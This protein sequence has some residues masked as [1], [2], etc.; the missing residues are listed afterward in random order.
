MINERG[1]ATLE[2]R[3]GFRFETALLYACRLHAKQTR[4]GGQT[5]YLGHL[6][7][8]ASQVIEMG[9]D[10]DQAI[11]AL[12]HDAIEDQGGELTGEAIR[13]LYGGRVVDIIR[14][15][16]DDDPEFAERT[17][18][19]SRARKERYLQHLS[20][21]PRDVLMVSLADKL[22]NARSILLDLH[23]LGDDLWGRFNAGK[24]DQLW[25]YRGLVSAFR[26]ALQGDALVL[27]VDELDRVVREIERLAKEA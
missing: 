20:K 1:R 10:E 25:Y 12:L 24:D 22:Y 11:A 16:S 26:E 17:A 19:N 15:C 14:Q 2:G 3:L 23:Q 9:G 27:V 4:K 6:L 7:G 13:S 5:P 8:V 21:A 18:E